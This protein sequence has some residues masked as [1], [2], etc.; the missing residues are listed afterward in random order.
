MP[1]IKNVFSEPIS[2]LDTAKEG[3]SDTED[4]SAEITQMESSLSHCFL[5]LHLKNNLLSVVEQWI[6]FI[7]ILVFYT[8]LGRI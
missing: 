8:A 4:K 7:Y 3:I 1:E 5:V 2:Q 6:L